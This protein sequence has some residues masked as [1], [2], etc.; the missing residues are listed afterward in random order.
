M[1]HFPSR[2]LGWALGF[3]A[4]AFV[5]YVGAYAV[6]VR[7]APTPVPGGADAIAVHEFAEPDSDS[8]ELH[9]EG[10]GFSV[11]IM[12]VYPFAQE[13]CTKAFAPIHEVDTK[14]RYEMWHFKYT[15][16]GL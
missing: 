6:L 1:R 10:Y 11:R 14:L 4:A 3:L 15:Q 13:L 8:N 2:E 16:P 12:A 7:P 5:L 9:F